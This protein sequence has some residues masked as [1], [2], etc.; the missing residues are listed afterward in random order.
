M[1]AEID[2]FFVLPHAR[3]QGVGEQLL[4]ATEKHLR[5][6]EFVCLQLQVGADNHAARAFYQRRGFADRAAYRLLD[7]GL[8]AER[9]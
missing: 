2:E 4:T 9:S 8:T 5:A 7:K 1:M 3:S 6:R